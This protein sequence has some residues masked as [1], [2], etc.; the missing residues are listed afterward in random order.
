MPVTIIDGGTSNSP[1]Q[2]IARLERQVRKLM[3]AIRNHEA[4]KKQQIMRPDF[5]DQELHRRARQIL[6]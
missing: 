5:T 6:R 4:S 2:R 1:R 3:A